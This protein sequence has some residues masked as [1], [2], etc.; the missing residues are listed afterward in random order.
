MS[1]GPLSELGIAWFGGS[2][3][4]SKRETFQCNTGR[5]SEH[6]GSKVSGTREEKVQLEGDK[7]CERD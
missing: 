4:E 7:M 2:P 6:K 1:F 3:V 5:M